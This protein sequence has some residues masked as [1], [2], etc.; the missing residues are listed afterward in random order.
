MLPAV[1]AKLAARPWLV[2]S[3]VFSLVTKWQDITT[4]GKAG[5][6]LAKGDTCGMCNVVTEKVLKKFSMMGLKG[7]KVLKCDKA[8]FGLGSKCRDTCKKV[9]SAMANTTGYPC[10]SAGLCPKV[11]DE[12]G[13]VVCKFSA[14]S[15]GCV[16]A[17]ACKYSFPAK[18]E[19]NPG[20][21]MWMRTT[22]AAT[23]GFQASVAAAGAWGASRILERISINSCFIFLAPSTAPPVIKR[24]IG[25]RGG[26]GWVELVAECFGTFGGG[27]A[28]PLG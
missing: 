17:N 1:I 21:R 10:E 28:A 9:V 7:D 19:L 5:F 22:Y 3:V 24:E 26:G 8:C 4:I 14:R 15:M 23:E 27:G 2:V 13:E 16:P 12:F 25:G 20:R 11:D 18:C 6:L